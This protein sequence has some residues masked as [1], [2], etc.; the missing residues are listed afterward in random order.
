M[1]K[2]VSIY[3]P[4]LNQDL[5][6]KLQK[7][8]SDETLNHTFTV[9]DAIDDE[10]EPAWFPVT[11]TTYS[12]QYPSMSIGRGQFVSDDDPMRIEIEIYNKDE[13][14]T[15]AR[16]GIQNLDLRINE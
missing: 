4:D 1:S 12:G 9:F 13:V 14:M 16:G 15:I 10:T 6:V 2:A 11:V 3:I 7:V 8:L 5:I